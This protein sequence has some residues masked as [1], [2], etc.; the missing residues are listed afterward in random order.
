MSSKLLN[1]CQLFFTHRDLAVFFNNPN[2]ED[3]ELE[4]V[5]CFETGAVLLHLL[6]GAGG[7]GGSPLKILQKLT[8]TA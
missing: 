7:F 3:V 5:E 4:E 2:D 6:F 1:I 8:R